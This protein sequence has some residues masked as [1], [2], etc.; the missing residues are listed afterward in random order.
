M[1]I[2]RDDR[3]VQNLAGPL[4]RLPERHRA[5]REEAGLLCPFDR[6]ES[7]SRSKET[8]HPGGKSL[9]A[10]VDI[11]GESG[12]QHLLEFVIRASTGEGGD[13]VPNVSLR[14]SDVRT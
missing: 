3:D 9:I 12:N 4:V 8:H 10:S 2:V 1:S 13:Y 14:F 11:V 7:R 5:H 6:I